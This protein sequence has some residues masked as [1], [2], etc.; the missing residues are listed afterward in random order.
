MPS[1][2]LAPGRS[3]FRQVILQYFRDFAVL[4]ETRSEYWGIQIVNFL[5]CSI[6]FAI[7]NIASVFL[8][9]DIGMDDK[10]AGYAIS[11]FTTATTILLFFSGAFTDWLGIRTSTYVSSLAQA[12]L[13]L[14]VVFVAMTPSL[15]Y[16]GVLATI[17]L[18]LMAP[19]MAMI[20]TVYQSANKRFTTERSRSAGFSLWYL[21]MNI[22]AATGGFLIDIIRMGLKWS[23]AQVFSVGAVFALLCC[24]ATFLFIRREDQLVGPD[25]VTS[26]KPADRG[27]AGRKKPWQ[28][29]GEV[30]REPALWR[31]LALIALILGTRAIFSYLY[32][33][34][35]KYWLRTIGPEA[36][37]GTLQAINPILIVVGIVVFLPFVNRF[38][39]FSMLVYG[40]MV[41]GLSLLPL[42]LPW[43]WI[44]A[45]IA[46]AHYLMSIFCMIILSVGEVIWSPKLYEYT[47]AIA[48]PGQEG[49]YLGL[50]MVPWFLAKTLVSVT[51]GHLLVRWC[52]E[53]IGAQMV[54]RA[55]GYW[56]TPAAMWLVLAAYA[57]G[58][59][60]IALFL[61]S[62][63]TRGLRSSRPA[64][65]G[66]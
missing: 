1:E 37:I 27:S 66:A 38:N 47:A 17:L 63:F 13:R 48:P 12:V 3:S 59:C 4:R 49:T 42:A 40:A 34:F 5:D 19:F 52:P 28:I 30:I 55:V 10:T 20:Q 15:P 22:G 53:G 45:D 26:A 65:A 9:E 2:T 61:R 33:L 24:L 44:S 58:G 21:F 64:P 62:W 18:F 23:N 50:S 25:E 46:R 39:V 8:S 41:S 11:L 14:G 29:A 60:V 32:L 35:P 51:S 43:Y 57:I 56:Q 7:L 31:L 6:F 16:R 36:T 54:D